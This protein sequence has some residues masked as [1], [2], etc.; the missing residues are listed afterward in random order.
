MCVC[1][2]PFLRPSWCSILETHLSLYNMPYIISC[3]LV[4]AGRIPSIKKYPRVSVFH[5]S[6]AALTGIR[7]ISMHCLSLISSTHLT[8]LTHRV[9][10]RDAPCIHDISNA[11]SQPPIRCLR[12]IRRADSAKDD[13]T[14][15]RVD[16]YTRDRSAALDAAGLLSMHTSACPSAPPRLKNNMTAPRPYLWSETVNEDAR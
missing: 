4:G 11:P 13:G 15:C 7:A 16:C 2:I 3:F 5:F 12:R 6:S 14:M 10:S 9:R 8:R 1:S